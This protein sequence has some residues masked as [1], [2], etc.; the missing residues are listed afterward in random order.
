MIREAPDGARFDARRRAGKLIGGYIAGGMIS[1][2]EAL[3]A[4]EDAVRGNTESFADAI[5]TLKSAIEYGQT[6]PISFDEKEAERLEYIGK[7]K[8]RS[9]PL[10]ALKPISRPQ[11]TVTLEPPKRPQ[12]TIQLPTPTRPAATVIFPLGG[13]GG[14]I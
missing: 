3:A 7:K 10:P 6:K 14:E 5:K 8:K 12:N 1:Y 4:L 2:G 11:N 13:G 9:V